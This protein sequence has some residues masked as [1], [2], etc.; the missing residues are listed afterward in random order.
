MLQ[1]EFRLLVAKDVSCISLTA[2]LVLLIIL[3]HFP[4]IHEVGE[5]TQFLLHVA[6]WR[7]YL[8]REV[9]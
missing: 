6:Q 9:Y 8:Q 7:S 4:K 1:A 2:G 3:S 5:L